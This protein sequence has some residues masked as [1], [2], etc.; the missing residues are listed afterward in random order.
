MGKI[1]IIKKV[2]EFLDKKEKTNA[3]FLVLMMSFSAVIETGALSLLVLLSTTLTSPEEIGDE[4]WYALITR[5]FKIGEIQGFIFVVIMAIILAY[6]AKTVFAYVLNYLQFRFIFVN[7]YKTQQDFLRRY[8]SRPYDYFIINSTARTIRIV[9]TDIPYIYAMLNTFFSLCTELIVSL[10]LFA[11]LLYVSWSATLIIGFVAVLLSISIYYF[12]RTRLIVAGEGYKEGSEKLN[13]WILQGIDNVKEIKVLRQERYILNNTDRYGK[14][15]SD[16]TRKRL[17]YTVAPKLLIEGIVVI[18]LMI[19]CAIYIKVDQEGFSALIP[20]MVAML[21]ASLRLLPSISR[22][23]SYINDMNYMA[24]FLKD[25]DETIDARNDEGGVTYLKNEGTKADDSFDFKSIS[26]KGLEYSY[27]EAARPVLLNAD[28]H[29]RKGDTVGIVGKSGAGKTTFVD[30][31]IGLLKPEKGVLYID[32]TPQEY[33]YLLGRVGYIP[34]KVELIEGSI[35]ENIA[36]GVNPNHVDELKLNRA[37]KDAQLEELVNQLPE[38]LDSNVGERGVRLSGGQCQ[39]VGIAR[40]L[41]T[42]ASLLVF[43]EATSALD[44]GTENMIIEAINGMKGKMTMI[45]IAHR[46][47]TIE[48]CDY[49]YEVVDGVLKRK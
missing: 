25:I 44:D 48:N 47:K 46:L 31:L 8:F 32:D 11:Y 23:N 18:A 13:K 22:M 21:M 20:T 41:Y 33:N 5:I 37:V 4:R 24:P 16:S 7:Q 2:F 30:I 10:L 40:A 17:L 39:R 35:R 45:I 19:F 12:F 1:K 9:S 26:I 43:D 36:F 28:F 27:P 15:Y 38:G 42:N 34:Q 6:V 49:V 14:L 3:V 29:I